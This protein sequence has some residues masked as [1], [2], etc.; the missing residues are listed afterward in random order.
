MPSELENYYL[1]QTE[2]IQS[3]LLALKNIIMSIHPLITHERKYQIPFFY[4]KG[5]KLA[6]LWVTRK[7]LQVG[8]IEDKCLQEPIEGV[9][10]KDKYQSIIVNPN[11][12]IPMGVIVRNLKDLIHLYDNL[13]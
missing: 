8:F 11:E 1:K 13:T 10:L 7:K 2:P 3:C 6:Y 5:K 12:D 4:Y 9:R